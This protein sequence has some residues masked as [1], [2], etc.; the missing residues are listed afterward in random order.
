MKPAD[1]PV[2]HP[3]SAHTRSADEPL[4]VARFPAPLQS[5]H[6]FRLSG[7]S[8]HEATATQVARRRSCGENDM[9]AGRCCSGASSSGVVRGGSLVPFWGKKTHRAKSCCAACGGSVYRVSGGRLATRGAEGVQ[10]STMRG[11]EQVR[12][13]VLWQAIT[14]P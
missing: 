6:W 11:C 5:K 3:R 13:R 1:A 8:G 4:G 7:A 12:G 14:F 2:A 10:D 9:A